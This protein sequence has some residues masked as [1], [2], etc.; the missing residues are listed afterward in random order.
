MRKASLFLSV[1]LVL[2]FGVGMAT[3]QTM[4][5]PAPASSAAER[6]WNSYQPETLSG[7]ISMFDAQQ[8]VMVLKSE[9]VPYNFKITKA[10]KI[11]IGG[12]RATFAELTNQTGSS[13][14]VTFVARRNGDFAKSVTVSE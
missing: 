9:G 5:S 1:S 12:A 14:S 11:E 4:K 6:N 2:L 7:T 13:A 8:H 10:T 3:A